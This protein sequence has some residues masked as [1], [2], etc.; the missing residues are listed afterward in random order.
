MLRCYSYTEICRSCFNVNFIV[1][2]NTIFKDNSLVHQLV[3]KYNF[4][5]CN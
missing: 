3:N 2:F 4:D 5:N 1:N